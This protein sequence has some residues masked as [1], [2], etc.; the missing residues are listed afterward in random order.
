VKIRVSCARFAITVRARG[1]V[2][3]YADNVYVH[4]VD[5][6]VRLPSSEPQYTLRQESQQRYN[7]YAQLQVGRR[8]AAS[9]VNLQR[10]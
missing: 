2:T 3:L 6:H 1:H 9:R 8:A 4:Y 5:R 7:V 10:T